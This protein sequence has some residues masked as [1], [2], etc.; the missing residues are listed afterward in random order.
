MN[1]TRSKM[2]RT[3]A[4]V[5]MLVLGFT[6]VVCGALVGADPE[7]GLGARV[8]MAAMLMLAGVAS[9]VKALVLETDVPVRVRH[10]SARA[11]S[12]Q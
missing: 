11:D 4:K 1:T 12:R 5:G 8:A 9:L 2:S 6:F 10:R 3:T 7:L